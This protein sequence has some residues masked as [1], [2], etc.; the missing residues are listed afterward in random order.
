MT[1][2]SSIPEGFGLET[3]VVDITARDRA[4]E[5]CRQVGIRLPT[6]AELA[7]PPAANDALA[8]V[9]PDAAD[10]ANLW[11]VNWFNDAS[12]AGRAAVPE[13]VVIPPALSGVESPIIMLLGNRFPMIGAHKV[14]A[15]YSCLAPRAGDRAV[16]PH[17]EPGGVA[18]HRQLRPRGHRHLQDHGVPGG[19]RVARGHV[20]GAVR[21]AWTGGLLIPPT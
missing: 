9:D 15:A 5:R 11:R 10:A 14:L 20:G 12:R 8:G 17:Q 18:V 3:E 13:H 7:D 1:A 19:G 16:R 21:V 4:V 6:F 2:F